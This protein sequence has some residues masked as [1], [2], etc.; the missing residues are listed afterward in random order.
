MSENSVI[1][2]LSNADLHD[3]LIVLIDYNAH[4]RRLCLRIARRGHGDED[5]GK[6]QTLLFDGVFGLHCDP[7]TALAP[8]A[9]DE[10]GAIRL[11]EAKPRADGSGEVRLVFLRSDKA[12]RKDT[13]HVVM[14]CAF[15]ARWRD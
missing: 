13:P 1:A 7:Q 8:L 5:A 15:A 10:V 9:E 3:R 6:T 11:F 4:G 14:F 2:A 12:T